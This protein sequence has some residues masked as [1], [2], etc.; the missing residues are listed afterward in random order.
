MHSPDGAD[1]SPILTLIGS[2]GKLDPSYIVIGDRQTAR[3]VSAHPRSKMAIFLSYGRTSP[4]IN[5]R[6][7]A[8]EWQPRPFG[9]Q[10]SDQS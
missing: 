2:L 4:A 1:P 6:M 9:M 3:L 8:K 7:S 5:R 10:R